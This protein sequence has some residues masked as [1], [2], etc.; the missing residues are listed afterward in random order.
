MTDESKWIIRGVISTVIAILLSDAIKTLIGFN[1]N[2]PIDGWDFRILINL[3]IY[4][5]P[6]SIP[7]FFLG[8]LLFKENNK[9]NKE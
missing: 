1:Y 7:Y 2:G 9:N 6:F 4:A 3:A 8:K 5:V